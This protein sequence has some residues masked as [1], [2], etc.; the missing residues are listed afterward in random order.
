[1]CVSLAPPTIMGK[2]SIAKV[3]I[4]GL[5]S[6]SSVY[7]SKMTTKISYTQCTMSVVCVVSEAVL[8]YQRCG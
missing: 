6:V 4:T 2:W 5:E 3:L 7:L 1:M 8:G